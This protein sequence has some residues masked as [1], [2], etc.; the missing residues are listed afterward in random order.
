M[1]RHRHKLL[2]YGPDVDEDF[3]SNQGA[4]LLKAIT[5]EDPISPEYQNSN[6]TPAA[7]P[8]RASIIMTANSRLRIRFQGDKGA[9]ARRF[10]PSPF[11]DE[12]PENER[13]PGFSQMLLD[14]RVAMHAGNSFDCAD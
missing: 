9:W 5:G 1:G 11:T 3:L 8:I 7:K 2:L 12:V 6:I 10:V 4:P 13:V 14:N